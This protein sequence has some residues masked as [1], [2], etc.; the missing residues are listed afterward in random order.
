MNRMLEEEKGDSD[1]YILSE[2]KNLGLEHCFFMKCKY[3]QCGFNL[4][5]AYERREE[6]WPVH[7]RRHNKCSRHHEHKIQAHKHKVVKY[8]RV[9]EKPP[10]FYLNLRFEKEWRK[11]QGIKGC[12]QVTNKEAKSR[13]RNRMQKYFPKDLF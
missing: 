13:E 6:G 3:A 9:D 4:K 2:S 5:F 7:I 8:M 11:E 1:C 12:L 10:H